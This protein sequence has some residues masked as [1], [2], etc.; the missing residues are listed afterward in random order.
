MCYDKQQL[1]RQFTT[2]CYCGQLR[3]IHSIIEIFS[4]AAAVRMVAKN[5]Q[6]VCI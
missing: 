5:V 6:T 1:K 4:S 3:P 2:V